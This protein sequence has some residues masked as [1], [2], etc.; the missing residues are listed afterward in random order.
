MMPCQATDEKF[1]RNLKIN[2]MK[3]QSNVNENNKFFLLQCQRAKLGLDANLANFSNEPAY[4][5]RLLLLLF[6]SNCRLFIRNI[7]SFKKTIKAISSHKQA[8]YK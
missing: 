7:T 2:H 8:S 1:P 6:L 3:L 5:S 4:K